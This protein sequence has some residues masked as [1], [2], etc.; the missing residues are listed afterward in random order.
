MEAGVNFFF[1]AVLEWERPVFYLCGTDPQ[2]L[3][4]GEESLNELE[5]A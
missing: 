3:K 2:S 1:A 4:V 5:P